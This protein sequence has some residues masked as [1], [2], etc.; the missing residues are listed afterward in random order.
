MTT[1]VIKLKV[2][3]EAKT[4]GTCNEIKDAFIQACLHLDPSIFEPYIREGGYFS[5]ARQIP[6]LTIT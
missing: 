5:G 2:K 1:K 6:V 4:A 3:K